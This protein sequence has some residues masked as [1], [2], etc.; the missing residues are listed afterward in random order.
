MSKQDRTNKSVYPGPDFWLNHY[1]K[2]HTPWDLGGVSPGVR[3]LVKRDFP[4]SGRV[5]IPG[6][7][8]GYEAIWLAGLGYAVTALDI[9]EPPLDF[10]RV[11]AGVLGVKVETLLQDMFRLDSSFDGVFDVFLEQ[12]CFCA[13][14]PALHRDYEILAHRVLK[15]GGRL[16]GV[17]MEVP[18]DDGPPYSNPPRQVLPL[19]P[20]ERWQSEGPEPLPA[21]PDRPGPEYLARFTKLH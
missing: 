13:I 10:L 15:P 14:S 4:P 18:F 21:N 1:N 20:P 8:R 6:C 2:G 3:M 5:F 7:G 9:V 16:L 12:T 11:Q 17:F 19:F